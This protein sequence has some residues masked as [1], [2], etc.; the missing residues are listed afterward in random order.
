MGSCFRPERDDLKTGKRVKY[1]KYRI[2]W[3]DEHGDRCSQMAFRDKQ[4][5]EALLA[6]IER[7]VERR[8]AGLRVV[9]E[10][11]RQKPVADLVEEF[12][13]EL[14]SRG[15]DPAGPHVSEARRIIVK[16]FEGC[17][18]KR[19]GD[20][21][22]DTFTDYLA[23]MAEA[24]KAPLTRKQHL[25]F[26]RNMLNWCVDQGW[27]E[28]S[29]LEGVEAP[30]VGHAGRRRRRRAYSD[31]ELR[32]LL[33][34]TPEPRRTLYLIAALSGYRRKELRL[35]E[36]QDLT[37][38]GDRPRWHLRAEVSKNRRCD[39]VPIVPDLQPILAPIWSRLRRHPVA[40][41]A[42]AWAWFCLAMRRYTPTWPGRRSSG[43][44]RT[45]GT[46]TSTRSGTPSAGSWGKS[47]P[48]KR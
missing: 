22:R 28:E 27:L 3:T 48:S 34:A 12:A 38:E 6:R 30:T 45:A 33:A 42:T 1:R 29:P 36:R 40:W 23:A 5:S 31:D 9:E 32:R 20:V 2:T 46:R 11:H 24:G 21:R 18:W 43:S 39:I 47:C 44:P 35:M 4:A 14:V 7:D 17:G 25:A 8:K 37:P 10:S 26:T 41:W 13:R 15:S 19:L 16:V